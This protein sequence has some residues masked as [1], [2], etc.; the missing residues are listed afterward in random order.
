MAPD[1]YTVVITVAISPAS[2][3]KNLRG[4]AS[5]EVPGHPPHLLAPPGRRQS[6]SLVCGPLLAPLP[7]ACPGRY[8]PFWPPEAQTT[9][10]LGQLTVNHRLLSPA[11]SSR[12][13]QTAMEAPQSCS[14]QTARPAKGAASYPHHGVLGVGRSCS[15]CLPEP[16]PQPTFLTSR[17]PLGLPRC[18]EVGW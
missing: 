8:V 10:C 3:N 5:L 14:S 15:A 13:P 18:S 9:A 11:S 16:S 4:S 17:V 1:V 6:K 7:P 2:P 12:L